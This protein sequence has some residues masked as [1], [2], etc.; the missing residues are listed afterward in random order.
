MAQTI[1]LDIKIVKDL[2][3]TLREL[4]EEV[5]RLREKVELEPP[6]GSHEWWEWSNAKALQEVRGGKGTVL[7]NKEEIKE[8]FNSLRDA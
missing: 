4:K 2:V 1:S 5:A 3:I 6:Y 7:H 8:F